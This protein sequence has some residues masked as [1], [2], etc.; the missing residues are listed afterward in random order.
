MHSSPLATR[1][2]GHCILVLMVALY[3]SFLGQLLLGLPL[4]SY[5]VHALHLLCGKSEVGSCRTPLFS[6]CLL[7]SQ[8][9]L[10]SD[11]LLF[12][13]TFAHCSRLQQLSLSCNL[14]RIEQEAFFKCTSL[15][16][17]RAPPT[18]LYIA[19]RAFAGCA[20]KTGKRTTWRGTYARGNAFDECEQLDKPKWLRFLPSNT[21]DKWVDE[22][23]EAGR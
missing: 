21:K 2:A 8:V 16:E 7:S 5:R 23:T 6:F 10:C 12:R 18:L 3:P 22:F 9:N 17:V 4:G 15:R 13:S 19:R 1:E 11:C 20:H 14:R